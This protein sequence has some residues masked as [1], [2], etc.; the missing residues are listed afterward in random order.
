MVSKVASDGGRMWKEEVV[1]QFKIPSPILP[2]G[3][4]ENHKIPQFAAV[5][6]TNLIQSS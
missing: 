1:S 4:G 2:L 6:T 3:T 5:G